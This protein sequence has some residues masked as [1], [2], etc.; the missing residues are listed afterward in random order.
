MAIRVFKSVSSSSPLKF[1]TK[2]SFTVSGGL[3]NAPVFWYSA[4]ANVLYREACVRPIEFTFLQN[5]SSGV[6]LRM[7][8]TTP[9]TR[10]IKNRLNDNRKNQNVLGR[11]PVLFAPMVAG[12]RAG[13][14][15][16]Q[17]LVFLF[18]E[19]LD[20]ALT[21]QRIKAKG[22]PHPKHKRNHQKDEQAAHRGGG[23]A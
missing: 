19:E 2:R 22:N 4:M 20:V 9:T 14:L 12:P 18:L 21:H 13:S 8:L 17:I 7:Y 3:G 11:N 16:V 23:M 10:A 6:S 15:G 5:S 1:D